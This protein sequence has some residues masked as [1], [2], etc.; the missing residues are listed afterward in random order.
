ML[1]AVYSPADVI[2][3]KNGRTIWA[4]QARENG[5]RVEYGIGDN[6]YAIPKSKVE[7][8]EC[9]GVRQGDSSSSGS[10]SGDMPA[11]AALLARVLPA[12]QA[13]SDPHR[14]LLLG[15]GP[16][17]LCL[18][19]LR[20][21]GDVAIADRNTQHGRPRRLQRADPRGR[22]RVGVC[23]GTAALP[24]ASGNGLGGAQARGLRIGTLHRRLHR[25]LL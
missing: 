24:A 13:A 11:F 3:L 7:R 6:S 2:H 10:S 22:G 12:R 8:I 1:A 23:G 19:D 18:V 21:D 5:A 15:P 16:A 14:V 9:G 25:V 17:Q 20:V 4:D